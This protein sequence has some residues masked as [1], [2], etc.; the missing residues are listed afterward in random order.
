MA[1]T[2]F[3]D[4]V[5]IGRSG[6]PP[7]I[8]T[9][10]PD[11]VV[12]VAKG[13]LQQYLAALCGKT[14][15]MRT[16]TPIDADV[17]VLG[18]RTLAEQYK[19]AVPDTASSESYSIAHIQ[20]GKQKLLIVSGSSEPGIKQGI[21]HVVRN[22]R[23][24]EGI[25]LLDHA[26]TQSRPFF[27]Q[28]VSHI[29]GYTR[30]HLDVNTG[31][32]LAKG[33]H[34][35]PE[36]ER[37]NLVQFWEPQR[38]GD[39]VDMLDFFGYNNIEAPPG[40]YSPKDLQSSTTQR[41][42]VF[43]ER[44]LR[45]GMASTA[46]I[47]GT[48]PGSLPYGEDSKTS[49]SE[50]YRGFAETAAR[51]SDFVLTHWVDAGGWKST[52]EHP[53]TIDVLQDLHQQLHEEFKRVNP[54]IESILSLWYL[55]HPQYQRWLSYRGVDTILTTGK[56]PQ[57]IGLAMSRT[58]KPHEAHKITAAG[59]KAAVWGWYMADHEL[60]YTMHV[61]T[62]MMRKYFGALPN[63]ASQQVFFHSLDNCQRGTNLYTVYVGARML[64]D[65][66]QDPEIPL[67]E[68]ARLVYGPKLETRVFNA[69]KAIAD[70]RCGGGPCRGFWTPAITTGTVRVSDRLT[71]NGVV[72]FRQGHQQAVAAWEAIK[73]AEIDPDYIP[74]IN[75][76]RSTNV[77]LDELK[78][79]TEA[80]AKFMQ[81]IQDTRDGKSRPTEV[82]R[83]SGA[84]EY[85]E[86]MR[87]VDDKR[88]TPGVVS[89]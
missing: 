39:Y 7:A 61:H 31:A 42:K 84:F 85:Y 48:M 65:P 32:R 36:Q 19:V 3:A 18:D 59:H 72:T 23:M 24:H 15:Q 49:Y 67:R 9:T 37:A 56:I 40:F 5:E 63:E 35:T 44:I 75:F 89:R 21:Y 2:T 79:H 70:V 13:R 16:T 8:V 77:L 34:A 29:G 64:W 71:S 81:Y 68:V 66:Y 87:T 25:L 6:K 17:I 12:A 41:R 60:L 58:Y 76:H 46:K 4:T 27:E 14:P 43:R 1:T 55:D 50:Y 78:G 26:T 57:D 83:A 20:R 80:V 28:R 10:Q 53:C 86:R 73:D 22:S 11:E 74:P 51:D 69:L 88:T 30:Q 52:P 82:P 45:N 33:T 38:L 54:R 47:D 62:N